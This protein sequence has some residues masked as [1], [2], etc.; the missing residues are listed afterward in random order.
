MENI[1]LIGFMALNV[2]VIR[3]S[4]NGHETVGNIYLIG[5]MA[6][7]KDLCQNKKNTTNCEKTNDHNELYDQESSEG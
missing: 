7:N 2:T 6:F 1:Y 4:H 3:V 5:S